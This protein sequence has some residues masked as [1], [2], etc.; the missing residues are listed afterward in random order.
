MFLFLAF[1]DLFVL[2]VIS[3]CSRSSSCSSCSSSLS[4]CLSP[5]LPFFLSHLFI[6]LGFHLDVAHCAAHKQR[7]A[8]ATKNF[9]YSY[10]FKYIII[11]A[12][13]CASVRS[14]AFDLLGHAWRTA[15][16]ANQED[17]RL[18]TH[19]H[20]HTHTCSHSLAR[21]NVEFGFICFCLCM[22]VTWVWESPAF[23]TSL[24]K[25]NV[26]ACEWSLAI[27]LDEFSPC[28]SF[29]SF[30]LRLPHLPISHLPSPISH[31][32]VPHL[33]LKRLFCCASVL[34]DC[35]HTIGVEFGTRIIEVGAIRDSRKGPSE[36]RANR[37]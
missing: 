13:G 36:A 28:F 24:S 19:T 3:F 23:C 37:N 15:E 10:I 11:G 21:M 2:V 22:Q 17:G 4:P 9:N 33:T 25:R 16:R 31:L 29:V 1:I 34:T 6:C 30:F 32:L 35:P 14:K 27:S 5:A 26:S 7:A 18:G 20:T 8:M 12:C